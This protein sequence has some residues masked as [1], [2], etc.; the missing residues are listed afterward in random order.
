MNISDMEDENRNRL[1]DIVQRIPVGIPDGWE[2]TTYAVGG[3]MY[4]GFSNVCTEKLVVISSQ[5][6]SVIDCKS[7]QQNILYRKLR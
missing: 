6:Q 4:V 2:K 7:R 1:L 5:G 3:L